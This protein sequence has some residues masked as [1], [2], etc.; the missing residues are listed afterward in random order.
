MYHLA[1]VAMLGTNFKG[2]TPIIVA[3]GVTSMHANLHAFIIF[4]PIFTPITP[5]SIAG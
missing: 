1:T 3:N 2:S 4:S 5:T